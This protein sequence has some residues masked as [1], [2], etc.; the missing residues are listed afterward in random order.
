MKRCFALVLVLLW[1][2]S[3]AADSIGGQVVST[4]GVPIPGAQVSLVGIGS[5]TTSDTGQFRITVPGG[6]VGKRVNVEVDKDHWVATDTSFI[7]PLDVVSDPVRLKM[8]RATLV[9]AI[10]NDPASPEIFISA[11]TEPSRDPFAVAYAATPHNGRL[12]ITPDVGYMTLL[13]SGGAISPVSYWHTP[14]SFEFPSLDVKVVNNTKSTV[15]FQEA[16][17]TVEQSQLDPS[18]V[19]VIHGDGYL[20]DLPLVNL[21]WGLLSRCHVQFNFYADSDTRTPP[22]LFDPFRLSQYKYSHDATQEINDG[23]PINLDTEL[24]D[25]GVDTQNLG[26]PAGWY[27]SDGTTYK[28]HLA[29]GGTELVSQAEVQARNQRAIGRFS[30]RRVEVEGV[31]DYSLPNGTAGAV[32]FECTIWLREQG[33]GAPAPVS[34]TYNVKFDV[35]R[36]NYSVSVPIANALTPGDFDRFVF[37]IAAEK[38]STHTFRLKLRYNGTKFYTSSQIDLRLFV[39]R[40]DAREVRPTDQ[41]REASERLRAR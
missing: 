41:L 21:G 17:F 26:A 7:V 14:F 36:R 27:Q 6:M 20:H 33:A 34:A 13:K 29:D 25:A 11:I 38:S 12:Q 15:F 30:N 8:R 39:D 23:R 37:K 32:A 18:P 19:F 28:V 1:S 35:D 40:S 2:A 10:T 3:A 22:L 9:A 4:D 31:I 5:D 24:R 16:V